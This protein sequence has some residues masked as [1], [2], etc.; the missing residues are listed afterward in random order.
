MSKKRKYIDKVERIKDIPTK[1]RTYFVVLR[2]GRRVSD[3][4]HLVY[5][6]AKSERSHWDGI[7]SRWQD[8]T[9]MEIVE[10]E[11]VNYKT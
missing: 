5:E 11:N 6:T 8:G 1:Y 10:C 4:N 7:L 2:S 3:T 9:S